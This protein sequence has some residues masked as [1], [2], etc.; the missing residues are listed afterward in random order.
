MARLDSPD[1]IFKT[2]G[3]KY[4]AVA[5]EIE[6]RY[7]KGQ[8][9]LVGTTSIEKNEI[10]SDFM[11]K[12]RIPHNIL[13][14]KNHEKEAKIL[15]DAGKP[16]AITVATNMAGRGVDIILGGAM[17]DK[18]Q[19]QSEEKYLDSLPYKKWKKAHADVIKAGGLH[20]IGTERHESRRI[21]NQ[22]R[23]RSGRQGDPGSSKFYL[24]LEDDLM[25]IFGGEQISGLMDRLKLPEDQP[26]ENRLISRAIEQAQVK[27]E[28]FHFDARKRVVEYDD[29]ANQ[30]REI[31]YS[32]RKRILEAKNIHEEI[33]EKLKAQVDQIILMSVSEKGEIDYD[34]AVMGLIEI[35]P[36]DD[37]SIKDIKKVARKADTKEKLVEF[38]EKAVMDAHSS[39]QA[40]V[41]EKIIWEIEKYAF[42]GSIDTKWIEHLDEMENLREGVGIRGNNDNERI[43]IYKTESYDLFETLIDRIDQELS[44]RIFRIGVQEAR[45]SE[46]Q[47]DQ[48]VTNI[49]Q[50]DNIGL[51]GEGESNSAFKQKI[52]Q[53]KIGRNDPCW[54]KSGKK[55][56]HCHYPQLPQ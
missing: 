27:V 3:G 44:R 35:V 54:C 16:G 15:S 39:R 52:N 34:T 31:I 26:I 49:D 28:G 23:G 22:L 36:F 29:I 56:K 21:D 19:N 2:L 6:E 24:S 13:N 8:P 51:M 48:M 11:K 40:Q 50:S 41:G 10:L 18:R 42:L 37:D 5:K 25:R 53:T 33:V 14:A 20:V 38:I 12:K 43:V 46:I 7:K 45:Q 17:P 30:Q 1:A 32:L 47:L 55:W 4:G 9:V